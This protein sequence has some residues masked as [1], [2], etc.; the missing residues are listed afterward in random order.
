MQ[1]RAY[2]ILGGLYN[3]TIRAGEH[4]YSYPLLVLNYV[5]RNDRV[6]LSFKLSLKDLH[7]SYGWRKKKLK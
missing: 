7:L 1:I 4:L 6:Y 3:I 5:V 2:N